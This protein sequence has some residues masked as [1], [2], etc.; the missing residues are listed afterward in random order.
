MG[1][2]F[3]QEAGDPS[4]M[5]K[6]ISASGELHEYRVPVFV[7][8][9][10]HAETYS[11][12]SPCFLCNSDRL[13][14]EEVVPALRP[15]DQLS[16]DQIYFVLPE[17][18]LQQRVTASDMAALAVKASVALQKVARRGGGR[19]RRKTQ[20]SPVLEVNF[21][22]GASRGGDDGDL[23]YGSREF[24]VKKSFV[25]DVKTV[26][27]A[28]LSR[29]GSMRKVQRISSKRMKLAVRSFRM[30]LSTIYEGSAM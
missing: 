27:G 18:K 1:G 21:D 10:L 25:V 9:V 30:K 24:E 2:C 28:S 4:R 23:R 15:D 11:S 16:P 26:R 6:V 7:S 17:S 19:R 29:S 13:Y 5:A 12:S 22:G 20:I 14:Y 8:Q 3:S